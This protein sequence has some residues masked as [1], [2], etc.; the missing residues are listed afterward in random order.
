MQ[1]GAVTVPHGTVGHVASHTLVLHEV[2]DIALHGQVG[3]D[4]YGAD[5]TVQWTLL[6]KMTVITLTSSTVLESDELASGHNVVPYD[7]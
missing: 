7:E 3:A 2:F 1:C 4:A 5:V 6:C